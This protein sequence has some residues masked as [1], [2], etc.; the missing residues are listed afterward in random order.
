MAIVD[1]R[2]EDARHWSDDKTFAGRA[3]YQS[4]IG[5]LLIDDVK[6]QDEG[7]Y[8]CRVD[9]KVQPTTISSVNLTVNSKSK[10]HPDMDFL[11]N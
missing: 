4:S 3:F 8:K 2:L 10:I 5:R 6:I 1:S 9:F 11:I 7:I